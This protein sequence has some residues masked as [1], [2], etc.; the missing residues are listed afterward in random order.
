MIRGILRT[1]FNLGKTNIESPNADC[2]LTTTDSNCWPMTDSDSKVRCYKTTFCLGS[3]TDR[4]YC[5]SLHR[6]LRPCSQ[7]QYSTWPLHNSTVI[8]PWYSAWLNHRCTMVVIPWSVLSWNSY[9]DET[10]RSPEVKK[11][12]DNTHTYI[13]ITVLNYLHALYRAAAI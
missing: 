10:E 6:L 7:N 12:T 11:N 2:Q 8:Q 5:W 3:W 4:G 1:L 9:T 13:Y